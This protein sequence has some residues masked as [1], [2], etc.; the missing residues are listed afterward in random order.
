MDTSSP[1]NFNIYF[2][3]IIFLNEF[4]NEEGMEEVLPWKEK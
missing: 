3:F 1:K 2:E 4:K